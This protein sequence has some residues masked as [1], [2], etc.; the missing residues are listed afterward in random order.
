MTYE[1]RLIDYVV[2]ARDRELDPAAQIAA[3]RFLQDSYAVGL[4]GSRVSFVDALKR[5]VLAGS[6]EAH[7]WGTGETGNA[8]TVA[9]INAYQI[10]NQEWDCVHE[11]AVVHPMAVIL[12][13]LTAAAE[14]LG[15]V[16]GEGF[17]RA[18]GTAVDVAAVL[19]MCADQPM[20][21]FR[22]G[23]CGGF[24]AVAGLAILHD[25]STV[26]LRNAL[27][28]AYSSFGG[29]MQAHA[30]GSST[31]PLQ[32]AMS[33]RS[34]V[35]AFDLAEAG[36][37]G[38]QEFLTGPFGFLSLIESDG[39]AE[40]Q[41]ASLGTQRE[42]TRVSHKPFPTGRAAHGGL[43]GLRSLKEQHDFSVDDVARVILRAPPLV[44]RLVAR[45]AQ[46]TQGP[47]YARLCFPYLAA[48][49]LLTGAVTVEDF[50]EAKLVC[51]ARHNLAAKVSVEQDANT[52]PNALSPQALHVQLSSGKE[53][54][55]T[56]PDVLGS[57]GCPLTETQHKRKFSAA[58]ASARMPLSAA[59]ASDLYTAVA[60]LAD[61][62]TSAVTRNLFNSYHGSSELSL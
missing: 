42:I 5:A 53:L 9:M 8:A 21:F 11:P 32:I 6:H 27:G 31:L 7:V 34:A 48:T 16:P 44:C 19:G 20:R 25:S 49:L 12:S 43:H 29:T 60:R 50:D 2:A 10:H 38:P 41:F 39:H 61:S 45:P 28:I 46:L 1:E 17:L 30:E 13:V 24:G 52:D 35:T 59:S 54:S 14:R 56:L 40:E 55:I 23:W 47:A 57:P 51:P 37:D 26:T 15:S 18:V 22:P 33:A 4:S 3:I 62:D 36:V 58:I